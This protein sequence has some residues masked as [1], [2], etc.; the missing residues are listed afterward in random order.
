MIYASAIM[1][2]LPIFLALLL[3]IALANTAVADDQLPR[4]YFVALRSQLDV[5]AQAALEHMDGLG[6]Q[7]LATRAYLRAGT[8]LDGRWSWTQQ[9]IDAYAGSPAQIALDAQID[10]VRAAFEMSNPGY[11]LFT[12]PQVRSLDLQL[13]RWNETPSIAKAGDQMMADVSAAIRKAGF[14]APGTTAGTARFRD[15]VTDYAP[16]PVPTLAAPGLSAHG[17]MNAVDF[18]VQ[19]GDSI[20]AGPDSTTVDSVWIAQ[21]WRDR[22]HAAV[23][24]SGARFKGPLTNPVEPWHYVYISP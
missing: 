21:G 7:L 19:K 5:R 8:G 22:L 11:S 13:T 15:L 20:I 3:A 9:Q 24:A 14:P 18:Q 17:R 10:Q 16:Q 1:K 2:R 6:R 12:N 4:K 23:I